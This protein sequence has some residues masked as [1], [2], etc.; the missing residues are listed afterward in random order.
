[1]EEVMSSSLQ[2]FV[3]EKNL[4]SR[5]SESKDE[6]L[7]KSFHSLS[8]NCQKVS[9]FTQFHTSNQTINQNYLFNITFHNLK[10]GMLQTS[11]MFILPMSSVR[12]IR[13]C[14]TA[15]CVGSWR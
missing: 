2:G 11:R 6:S 8:F 7:G 13:T 14:A 4:N 10:F 5:R 9:N 3:F 1:M 12:T 15:R